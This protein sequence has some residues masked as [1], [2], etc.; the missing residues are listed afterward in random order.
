[1]LSQKQEKEG[2]RMRTKRGR[3]RGGVRERERRLERNG[4]GGEVGE[5]GSSREKGR[6]VGMEREGEREAEAQRL[7]ERKEDTSFRLAGSVAQW[8]KQ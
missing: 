5:R 8:V 2:E 1:M 7:G 3:E 6:V 4:R